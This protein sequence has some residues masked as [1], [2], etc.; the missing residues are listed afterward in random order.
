MRTVSHVQVRTLTGVC[1]AIGGIAWVAACFV[2]NSLPR[3]CIGDQCADAPMRGSSPVA[4]TLFVVTGLMLAVSGFGLL[5]IAHQRARLGRVGT[6]AGIT[7]GLGLLLLAA[8]G[9]VSTIDNDWSGMPGL[10]VPGIVLLAVGLVLVAAVVLRAHVVPTWVGALVLGTAVL[11]PFANEQTSLILLA[12]PFGV[13]WLTS[14][15]T[16]LRDQVRGPSHPSALAA[17]E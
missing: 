7:A 15:L 3:G 14:G 12:V 8:A 5:V 1:S 6:L 16:L 10:V 4:S 2:H 17:G 9:V 11:L 13:A